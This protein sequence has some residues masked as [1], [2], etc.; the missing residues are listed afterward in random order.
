MIF[1]RS[2][3]LHQMWNSISFHIWRR[4]LDLLNIMITQSLLDYYGVVHLFIIVL[5]LST[6]YLPDNIWR[7]SRVSINSYFF[8]TCTT[9][10]L[11]VS[12]DRIFSRVNMRERSTWFLQVSNPAPWVMHTRPDAC[13]D[14]V[15]SVQNRNVLGEGTRRP[16]SAIC[17]EYRFWYSGTSP[18]RSFIDSIVTERFANGLLPFAKPFGINQTVSSEF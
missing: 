2:S 14:G 6:E 10:G 8:I 9:S 3:L 4:R 17:R 7:K 5:F 18:G 12:L 1:R 16:I 13:S 15:K 11:L